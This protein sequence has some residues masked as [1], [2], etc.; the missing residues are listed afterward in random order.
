MQAV[1]VYSTDLDGANSYYGNAFFMADE[2]PVPANLTISGFQIGTSGTYSI[3]IA[4]NVFDNDG[5]DSES[6]TVGGLPYKCNH[7]VW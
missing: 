6:I 7:H 4:V 3:A 1:A 2:T 5:I